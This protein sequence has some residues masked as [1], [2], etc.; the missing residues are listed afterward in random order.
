MQ[1]QHKDFSSIRTSAL[2]SWPESL[3]SSTVANIHIKILMTSSSSPLCC[4][5]PSAQS[6][7]CPVCSFSVP[8]C[9]QSPWQLSEATSLQVVAT[10]GTSQA[11][12]YPDTHISSHATALPVGS[13]GP[14]QLVGHVPSWA[15]ASLKRSS[16]VKRASGSRDFPVANVKP[17]GLPASMWSNMFCPSLEDVFLPCQ[18]KKLV[19]NI[20]LNEYNTQGN[21]T[22]LFYRENVHDESSCQWAIEKGRPQTLS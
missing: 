1:T 12:D 17:G 16:V 7:Y 3:P 15:Q 19:K 22:Q 13:L 9:A 2:S 10:S 4:P 8:L 5:K 14:P 20:S 6:S 18:E 21:K 11:W